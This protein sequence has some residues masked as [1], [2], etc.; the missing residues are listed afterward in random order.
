MR[1]PPPP[2][3]DELRAVAAE[4]CHA[5]PGYA[6]SLRLGSDLAGQRSELPRTRDE[7]RK[8]EAEGLSD[9]APLPSPTK[10]FPFGLSR[11]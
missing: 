2:G 5:L 10:R 8:V 4:Q 7:G 9:G 11:R 3:P 6:Q 1:P